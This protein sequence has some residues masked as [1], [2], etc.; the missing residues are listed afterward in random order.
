MRAPVRQYLTA[1][2]GRHALP[3]AVAALADEFARLI[4]A[5]HGRAL[6][7]WAGLAQKEPCF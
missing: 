2:F 1:L 6:R 4:G 7:K 5:L 3:E